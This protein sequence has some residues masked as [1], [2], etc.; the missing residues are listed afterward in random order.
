MQSLVGK[1]DKQHLKNVCCSKN[2]TQVRLWELNEVK[3]CIGLGPKDSIQIVKGQLKALDIQEEKIANVAFGNSI[4]MH[5]AASSTIIFVV[6]S[7]EFMSIEAVE[8][9]TV[10]NIEGKKC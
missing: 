9:Q 4:E 7:W 3:Q 8:R 2:G 5:L 1:Q 10:T 6:I